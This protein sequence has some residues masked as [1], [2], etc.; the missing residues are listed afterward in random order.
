MAPPLRISVTV[1][2][3][4]DRVAALQDAAALE[5]AGVDIIGVAEAYGLDGVSSLGYLAALTTRAQVMSVI[6]PI[7]PRTPT[8]TAMTA[9]GL[10]TLSGGRFVLGLGTSGPQVVE[11]FHGVP[12]TA[13]IATTRE[14]V[15]ICRAVW[16]GEKL[17]HHGARYDMPLPAGRGTGLG[18]PLK[19]IGPAPRTDI[20][21]FIAAIGARNV[22]LTAEIAEGWLPFMYIPERADA[23]WGQ[24]LTLGRRRRSD[25]LGPLDIVAGGPMAIGAEH[26]PL[27]QDARPKHALYIGGMGP[28]GRN[29]Y[30]TLAGRYGFEAEAK[31]IQDLY[32]NG[33]KAE[34]AAA[35]PE[36][37]LDG[38][39]LIGDA[40]YVRD[41]L[42]A[43]ADGG[44]T[45]LSVDPVGP[46]PVGDI[47]R[48]RELADSL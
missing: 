10:D 43:Y 14:V 36:A 4:G 23:V 19:M 27:R 2:N 12:Y 24:S 1:S 26:V 42:Q 38:T 21:V 17:D 48:L 3:T 25:E 30:N 29:F 13:P 8:T 41:R 39:S 20:P 18:K 46:D 31:L 15:E 9:V 11:G 16:R 7:Y 22:E 37:I 45:I 34:A 28:R 6:L 47:R 32:L 44:V 5:D 40:A 33:K 35:V